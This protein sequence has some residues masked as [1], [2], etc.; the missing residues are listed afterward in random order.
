MQA[1]AQI[2][3]RWLGKRPIPEAAA[4]LRVSPRCLRYLLD[5]EML[6]RNGTLALIEDAVARGTGLSV[7]EL[8]QVVANERAARHGAGASHAPVGGKS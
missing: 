3:S 5:G 1:F 8:R 7:D 6:P 2:L 4:E